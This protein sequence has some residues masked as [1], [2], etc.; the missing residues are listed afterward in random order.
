MPADGA[1]AAPN[2]VELRITG[3]TPEAVVGPVLTA[4][5]ARA[6]L[7]IQQLDELE[8]ATELLLRGCVGSPVSVI[9]SLADHELRVSVGPLAE[10]W[11]LRRSGILEELAGAVRVDGERAELRAGR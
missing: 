6:G 9:I 10:R 7:T 2:R 5:G 11:A 3:V 1:A 4:M 8:L